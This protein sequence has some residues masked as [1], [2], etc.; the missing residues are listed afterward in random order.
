M[1]TLKDFENWWNENR[2]SIG[3][4]DFDTFLIDLRQEA[5]KLFKNLQGPETIYP[6]I[7]DKL[8]DDCKGEI[9]KDNWNETLFRYGAEYGMLALLYWFNSLRKGDLK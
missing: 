5:I 9:A 6:I 3:S 7:L 2:G 8:P 4:L 1:R